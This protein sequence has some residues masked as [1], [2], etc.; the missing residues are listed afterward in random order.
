MN[1]ISVF[2]L[3]STKRCLRRLCESVSEA[4]ASL[5]LRATWQTFAQASQRPCMNGL[6]QCAQQVCSSCDKYPSREW[7][8][9]IVRTRFSCQKQGAS[10]D[11]LHVKAA[12]FLPPVGLPRSK[13]DHQPWARCSVFVPPPASRG[14]ESGS[15][16]WNINLNCRTSRRRSRMT[17]SRRATAT[18]RCLCASE[19]PSSADICAALECIEL[20]L[21]HGCRVMVQQIKGSSRCTALKGYSCMP[22]YSHLPFKRRCLIPI[23]A[24]QSVQERQQGGEISVSC[25]K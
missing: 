9:I 5:L 6:N 10:A 24:E 20:S 12:E 8:I 17:S 18:G 11:K 14:Q 1:L 7:F 23:G 25:A 16:R 19:P 4:L 22:F 15:L 3:S 13:Q 2:G 21:R